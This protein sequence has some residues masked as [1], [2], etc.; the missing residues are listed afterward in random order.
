MFSTWPPYKRDNPCAKLM[1]HVVALRLKVNINEP[2]GGFVPK[3]MD[4]RRVDNRADRQRPAAVC[5]DRLFLPGP[6][7]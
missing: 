3:W 4:G 7:K 2:Y 6:R 5:S 1:R